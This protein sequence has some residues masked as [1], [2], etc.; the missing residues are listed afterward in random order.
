M[1]GCS[2]PLLKC[3]ASSLL[4]SRN[5]WLIMMCLSPVQR[6]YVPSY[7]TVMIRIG[8]LSACCLPNHPLSCIAVRVCLPDYMFAP[9]PLPF[10][11]H[12]APYIWLLTH[13]IGL[14]LVVVRWCL[15]SRWSKFCSVLKL[16]STYTDP[17]LPLVTFFCLEYPHNNSFF[18]EHPLHDSS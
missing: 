12:D 10:S 7:A 2:P 8:S 9:K 14:S 6:N 3:H 5:C 13:C 1:L 15:V 18:W 17:L 11:M 16:K 4:N